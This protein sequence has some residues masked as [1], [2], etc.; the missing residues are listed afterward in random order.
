[1]E[2]YVLNF[3]LPKKEMMSEKSGLLFI[4]QKTGQCF[5]V[6]ILPLNERPEITLLPSIKSL[7]LRTLI[8]PKSLPTK[9]KRCSIICE[10][11]FAMKLSGGTRVRWEPLE[12]FFFKFPKQSF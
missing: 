7:Q 5:V 4:N 1:M 10:G 3:F 2:L 6:L 8:M 9:K 11:K 12:A